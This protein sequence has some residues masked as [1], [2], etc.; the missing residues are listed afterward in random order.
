[1]GITVQTVAFIGTLIKGTAT[2]DS[3]VIGIQLII[4][5]MSVKVVYHIRTKAKGILF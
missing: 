2:E 4:I 3:I 1:M 5:R